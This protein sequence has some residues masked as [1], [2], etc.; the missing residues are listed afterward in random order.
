[1]HSANTAGATVSIGAGL[2]KI[3]ITSTDS[4]AAR[5]Q[6]SEARRVA[7]WFA[8]LAGMV[9]LTSAR[10]WQGGLVMTDNK[11]FVPYV[12]VLL[13]AMAFQ[14]ALWVVLR[15]A[16]RDGRLLP[17]WLWRGSAVLDLLVPA[18]LLTILAWRSPRGAIPAL[19][20]PALL[21]LPL[22]VLTSVLRLRPMFTL[23][24][25]IAA[26]AVHWALVVNAIVLLNPPRSEYPVYFA[27]GY[28]LLLTGFAATL[29]SREVKAHVREAADEA[30]AH[31]SADRAMA[32]VQ[33][34]LAVARDIQTGLLPT[35]SPEFD[36]YEI[37]GMNRPAD[38]T[39]GDYYDWQELPD[40]RL[41]VVM[42]DVTGHGI[43]P[44]LVMAVCR[45]YA[46]ASAPIIQE[47]QALMMRLNQLLHTDLPSD[48]F[49][50]FVMAILSPDGGVQLLSAGHGPT[51][52]Y[53]GASGEVRQFG[54]DGLPLGI[55]PGE[56]YGPT[57]SFQM[58]PGDSL[59][60]LT[61]GFFEWQRPGD[62]ESFGIPRLCDALLGCVRQDAASM[63]RSMDGAV[64]A[65]TTGSTQPDD[66]TAV[67]IKRTPRPAGVAGATPAV[68]AVEVDRTTPAPAVAAV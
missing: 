1:M 33:R 22:V 53:H 57:V 24:T 56:E 12:G 36:G 16:N 15:R 37:A 7:V 31:E 55:S 68:G 18:A 40:G 19:S 47:P 23:Y 66:M 25:G 39:G 60:L 29:V 54:G 59:V 21:L 20:A 34:D 61:D 10:R 65:F 35:R 30:A 27:Y 2:A 14:A 44:A 48:R 9:L 45:A 62:D 49:I 26:A 52:L 17:A 67:V 58:D 8:V 41:A 11:V 4:F 5:A 51:L 3:S 46:R 38:L 63:I 28:V 32:L 13:L 50:T 6:R 42:A 43:G 64:R